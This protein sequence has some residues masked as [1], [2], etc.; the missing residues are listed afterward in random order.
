MAFLRNTNEQVSIAVPAYFR[1]AL[2]GGCGL[3]VF[4]LSC[5]LMFLVGRA[6]FY[7]SHEDGACARSLGMIISLLPTLLIIAAAVFILLLEF[8]ITEFT[9]RGLFEEPRL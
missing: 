4:S 2:V 9:S 8:W 3:I 6:L 1:A 5:A 7:H